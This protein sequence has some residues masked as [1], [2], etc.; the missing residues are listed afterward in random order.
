MWCLG[1]KKGGQFYQSSKKLKVLNRLN[2][3]RNVVYKIKIKKVNCNG[4]R[5][6]WNCLLKHVFK[7]KIEKQ[8]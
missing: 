7:E 2:E 1:R 8:K 5:L 6:L 3:E 4:H